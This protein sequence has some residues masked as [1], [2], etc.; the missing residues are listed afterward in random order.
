MFSKENEYQSL[1]QENYFLIKSKQLCGKL[2]THPHR[3]IKQNPLAFKISKHS[4]EED[5]IGASQLDL[6]QEVSSVLSKVKF[7]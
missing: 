3:K 4:K 7:I 1:G 6:I 5:L 2:F